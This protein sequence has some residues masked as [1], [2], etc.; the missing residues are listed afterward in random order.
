[1][2]A[3]AA[4]AGSGPWAAQE[5]QFPPALLS[6]FIYNP[7]F[8]PRE[9]EEE[10]KILFYH[11]NEV[12]KNEKI[13]NVGLCEAIV[14]FTRTFSPSKPAKSLHTQKNRQFFNEPEE[15]FWMVMIVRNP[16]IEKQSKDGKPVIEYQ[17]EEL[18]DKVYSSVLQQCYSMYKLFNGTFLKAME[19]GGV[20]LLK[21]RLEKF[22]HRVST[23]NF[24][25]NFSEH[26]ADF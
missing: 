22:F 18:L 14:Q 26:S 8:G 9:G 23:L 7:R 1:M 5:K 20:E 21:E 11:P 6:F 15:H 3:A 12:E 25:Y 16:I 19:D 4:G 13:R 10:N 2:A 17:E 24:I